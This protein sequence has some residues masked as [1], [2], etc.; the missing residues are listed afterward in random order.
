MALKDNPHVKNISVTLEVDKKGKVEQV[1]QVGTDLY[2]D[3]L[4]KLHDK[5]AVDS[6]IADAVEYMKAPGF[7][8]RVSLSGV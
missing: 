4:H 6:V 7:W 5:A 2:L 3:G 8:G 1:T